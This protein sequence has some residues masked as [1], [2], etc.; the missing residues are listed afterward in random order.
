MSIKKELNWVSVEERL[1]EIDAFV[2][3]EDDAGHHWVEELDKDMGEFPP[4]EWNAK[5]WAYI[6]Y[7]SEA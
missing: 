6:P 3:W 2:L 7:A 1:P 5:Y 4:N